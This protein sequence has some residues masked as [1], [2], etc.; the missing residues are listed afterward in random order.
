MTAT[1]ASYY[2][3]SNIFEN[4]NYITTFRISELLKLKDFDHKP[5]PLKHLELLNLFRPYVELVMHYS[6]VYSAMDR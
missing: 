4:I 6:S 1:T 5:F 3:S 2:S